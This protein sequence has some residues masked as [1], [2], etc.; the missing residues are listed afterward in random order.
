MRLLRLTWSIICRL[1]EHL[2]IR[3]ETNEGHSDR[4]AQE[5]AYTRAPDQA[6]R[7]ANATAL[8]DRAELA[9]QALEKTG[10]R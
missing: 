7:G 10:P 2:R 9:L 1:W 8:A 5:A 3:R 4:S 6:A